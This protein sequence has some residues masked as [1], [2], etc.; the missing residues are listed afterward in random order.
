MRSPTDEEIT[1]RLVGIISD[2]FNRA[3]GALEAAGALDTKKMRGHYKGIGSK[4]YDI[5][6]EQI[7][8]A[9]KNGAPSVRRLFL[10]DGDMPDPK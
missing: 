8:L 5:V 9:A 2:G 1:G 4:Y 3:I 10:G 6:T 7:E